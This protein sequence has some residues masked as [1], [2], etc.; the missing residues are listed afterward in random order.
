MPQSPSPSPSPSRSQSPALPTL[1]GATPADGAACVY[2]DG[3]CP[4]CSREIATYRGARGG[5]QL[6]WVDA[7][8][9]EGAAL[10]PALTREAALARLHVRLPD[11]RLI[12]GA[13]AFVAIW[14]QLPAFRAL[15]LLARIPGAVWVM[16]GAY[17][18]FLRLRPLWRSALADTAPWAGW[19]AALRRELRT[20]HAGEAGAVMIYRGVLALARDAGLREFARHHL[21]TEA[22]HLSLIEAQVPR[23]GRSRLLPLWRLAGWLTGAL[24]A[25]LG[26]RAVY[27]T[28]EAVEIFVDHHY[29]AQLDQ[30]DALLPDTP[31][32]AR[33]ALRA[34]RA[35]LA[36]CQRD[37][38]A[39]RDEAR[40]RQAHATLTGPA[41]WLA[42]GWAAVVGTGSAG[43]VRVSRWL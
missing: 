28:I 15:A 25:C 19:P 1:P 24:P 4:L 2:F 16:E 21:E 12:S 34:L 33:P 40:A 41:R 27:A 17:R 13:R 18:A 23:A 39:H 29:A 30:I 20:D 32:E 5:D 6:Q 7:A 38:Q 11:G 3:A 8:A 43:A 26:P 9:C 22:R 37:E 10:G 14:E 35:L 31:A 36:D 42:A